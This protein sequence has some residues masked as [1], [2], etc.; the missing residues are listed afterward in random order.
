MAVADSLALL[1]LP[2]TTLEELPQPAVRDA[3]QYF[4]RDLITIPGPR[5]PVA[6]AAVRDG[7]PNRPIVHPQLGHGGDPINHYRYSDGG[8]REAGDQDLPPKTIDVIAVQRADVLA[9]L[10]TQLS[11]GERRTGSEG[12]TFL[13]VPQLTVEWDTTALSSTLPNADELAAISSVLPEPMTVLA[14]GQPATY[15]HEWGLSHDGSTVRVPVAG[16]GATDRDESKIAQCTC[17]QHGNVGAEAVDADQ[18]GLRALHGVGR[19]T[20]DQLRKHGCQTTRD[21]RDLSVSELTERPGIGRT[22]AEKIHA[23]AAVID[24]SE[25]L[26]LTN[27][28]PVKTCDG[29]PPLC[30]DIETDGLTPTIIWQIG[31]YDPATDSHQ[32]FIEKTNPTDPAPVLEAFITWLLAN[33]RDRTLLTWNGHRF[34]Y[35]YI[36]QFL[37]RYHPEYVEAWDGLWTYDLYRWAVRDG[38]ALLPGRTNKLDH[39]ARATGYESGDTALTGAQTAAAYQR[40]MRNPKDPASEPDWERHRAYCEDDCRALWY[41][42]RTVME[43]P[44]RDMTD[45]GAGGAD[46]QQAGLTD[47]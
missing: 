5:N 23:H 24:S 47:F 15:A 20:A 21:V 13:I 26:V 18:F 11:T 28:T 7:A 33:H 19:S 3:L 2:S 17:T 41:V 27:K 44:R 30:L 12:A 1:T 35:R 14:G 42:Y 8:V 34:D 39:V 45:S 10:E 25:P 43:A 9:R 6:Y 16:L 4:E 32:A 37:D 31:V 46:G 38:N 36:R 40:F 29:R 22:T